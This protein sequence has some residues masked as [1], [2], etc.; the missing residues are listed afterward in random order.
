MLLTAFQTVEIV[1]APYDAGTWLLHCH[2]QVH[3]E[4][5][6]AMLYDVAPAAPTS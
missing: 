3:A 5:G 2:I 4:Y 6:M 1:V